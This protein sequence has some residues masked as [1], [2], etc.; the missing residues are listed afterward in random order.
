MWA[1]I[2]NNITT[3]KIISK[4]L[5]VKPNLNIQIQFKPIESY[6]QNFC[7]MLIRMSL[8]LIYS[9]FMHSKSTSF[10]NLISNRISIGFCVAITVSMLL[11]CCFYF[12]LIFIRIIHANKLPSVLNSERIRNKLQVVSSSTF[13]CAVFGAFY[14][15]YYYFFL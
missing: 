4:I 9:K 1:F 7:W 3:M 11:C 6:R 15:Y 13:E 10:S 14:Y 8:N 5:Y 2:T 12:S